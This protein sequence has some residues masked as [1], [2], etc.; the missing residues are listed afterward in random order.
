[1]RKE[2]VFSFDSSIFE[3][4]LVF[5]TGGVAYYSLEILW[6]GYSHY[7]MALLGGLCFLTL[8]LLGRTFPSI[9]LL[10]YCILGSIIISAAELGM[11]EIL[12]NKL[13]MDIWDYSNIPLNFRGQVCLL[14]SFLW[15]L[16]CLPINKLSKLMRTKIFGYEK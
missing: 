13:G 2:N 10:L 3:L 12:N 6:R 9:P 11:G 7:S 14:F 16:L 15:S 5:A 4:T 1:M 8:Y